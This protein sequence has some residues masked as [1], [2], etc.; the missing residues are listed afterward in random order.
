MFVPWRSNNS[1]IWMLFGL[2]GFSRSFKKLRAF[3]SPLTACDIKCLIH[4][5]FKQKSNNN[6]INPIFHPTKKNNKRIF[7]IYSLMEFNETKPQQQQKTSRLDNIKIKF[8]FIWMWPDLKK[9]RRLRGIWKS[10]AH[11]KNYVIVKNYHLI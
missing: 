10:N 8:V 11:H 5:T 9:N 7:H 2:D 3:S 6:K 1:K 4:L